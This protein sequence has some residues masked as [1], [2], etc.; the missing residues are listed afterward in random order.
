MPSLLWATLLSLTAGR[1]TSRDAELQTDRMQGWARGLVPE[2]ISD[3]TLQ[4]RVRTFDDGYLCGKLEA[5]VRQMHR[6]KLLA[7]TVVP[8]GVATVDGKNLATLDHD[9]DGRAHARSS[10][11]DK[12][13]RKGSGADE[14][15]WL[16]PVLRVTLTSAQCKPCILQEALPPGVGEAAHFP[17]AVRKLEQAYGR[18]GLIQAID[19]DAGLCSLDNADFVHQLGFM[20]VFG[21]KGN[22]PSL[23]EAAQ[24]VL[25]K[26]LAAYAPE[27]VTAWEPRDGKRI[28]R[29]LW[30]SP[31]LKGFET[32][33][34]TWEHL[35]QVWLVRQESRDADGN[36]EVEDR[37]FVTSIPW[38]QLK[39]HQVLAVVR[40]HWGVEND[41][42]NSLDIQWREDHG[43]WSTKGNAVWALGALR[44]MAYNVAQLLRRRHLCPKRPDG[45]RTAPVAWS[46]IFEYV[47]E[48]LRLPAEPVVAST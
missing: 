6:D 10:D 5:Q 25:Y 32:T 31:Q 14:P 34:G 41:T 36:L 4:M 11:N 16:V 8:L 48:A 17:V 9:A 38:Q 15:Y 40:G 30:R 13:H 27:A 7:L 42:F 44:V 22:Q 35:Q 43:P 37:F 2:P 26:Q 47:R 19:G 23:Y 33:V 20:Y 18:S 21:L 46:A 24:V 12:W 45:T 39:P 29:L 28:R 3:T 1:K